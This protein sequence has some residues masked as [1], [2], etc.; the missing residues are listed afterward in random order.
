MESRSYGA[1]R[2]GCRQM[3]SPK[4]SKCH[5]GLLNFDGGR[6]QYAKN[7]HASWDQVQRQADTEFDCGMRVALIE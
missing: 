5:T 2:P 1:N 3:I 7:T 6:R 4:E